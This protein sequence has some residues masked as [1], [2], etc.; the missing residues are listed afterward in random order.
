[1]ALDL[2][3]YD[4]DSM[5]LNEC[6][7]VALPAIEE[8]WRDVNAWYMANYH[9]P[10]CHGVKYIDDVLKMAK[11]SDSARDRLMLFA[12]HHGDAGSVN[13]PARSLSWL[14]LRGEN[15]AYFN[16]RDDSRFF[17]RRFTFCFSASLFYDAFP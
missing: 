13:N 5:S 17:W 1:M 3:E 4:L 7:E 14:K 10:Y 6:L 15:V 12:Y 2:T 11:L 8:N 9:N 16:A